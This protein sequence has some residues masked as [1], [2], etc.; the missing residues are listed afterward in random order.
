MSHQQR[1]NSSG[2]TVIERD[3]GEWRQHPPPAFLLE[4]TF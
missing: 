4:G 2:L 1:V 3:V